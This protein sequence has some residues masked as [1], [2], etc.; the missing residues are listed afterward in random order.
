LVPRA[1][2][3]TRVSDKLEAKV[4]GLRCGAFVPFVYGSRSTK[5]TEKIGHVVVL[6]IV[7]KDIF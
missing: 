1:T 3:T 7:G 5:E 6:T 2:T 4:W